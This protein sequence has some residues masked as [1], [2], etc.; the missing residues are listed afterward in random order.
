MMY[1]I[2]FIF[3]TIFGYAFHYWWIKPDINE[4]RAKVRK[5]DTLREARI[6]RGIDL[7][8][9]TKALQGV[10]IDGDDGRFL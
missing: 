10:D 5:H 7:L 9:Q 4:L 6:Q 8:R 1:P 3:G 2:A